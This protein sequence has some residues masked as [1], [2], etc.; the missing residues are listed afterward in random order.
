M[1]VRVT[2]IASSARAARAVV[3]IAYCCAC[4]GRSSVSSTASSTLQRNQFAA[5]GSSKPITPAPDAGAALDTSVATSPLQGVIPVDEQEKL[6]VE[7]ERMSEHYARC[8]RARIVRTV[9][10]EGV[11]DFVV[12]AGSKKGVKSSWEAIF[13]STGS[14]FVGWTWATITAV[15]P[16]ATYVRLQMTDIF[17]DSYESVLLC[18]QD[19][20][21]RRE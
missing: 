1:V 13:T 20:T 4:T 21:G 17:Q 8:I 15:K 16:D 12:A 7:F 3:A 19:D 2:I 5:V 14:G 9:T 6:N 11:T 18:P 10:G